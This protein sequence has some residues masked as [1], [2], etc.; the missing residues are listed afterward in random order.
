L[1]R[2]QRKTL[3][4]YFF[5]AFCTDVMQLPP[6]SL[7]SSFNQSF[8]LNSSKLYAPVN[9]AADFRNHHKRRLVGHNSDG[10]HR[11]VRPV[12]GMEGDRDIRGWHCSRRLPGDT[13][14][15]L[16]PAERGDPACRHVR[17]SSIPS[18]FAGSIG[19]R[20]VCSLRRL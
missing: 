8:K 18:D 3:G 17:R 16:H 19:C 10:L 12:A 9:L 6:S 15:I 13:A 11:R 5:A 14:D 1:L 20:R 2:K 4:G 7:S